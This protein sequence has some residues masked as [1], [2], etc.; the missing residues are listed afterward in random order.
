MRANARL[1][2]GMEYRGAVAPGR[3]EPGHDKAFSIFPSPPARR[4]V[5]W[6]APE[7]RLAVGVG[8]EGVDAWA[9]GGYS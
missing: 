1:P 8:Q 3:V 6:R 5:R 9:L 7:E 2:A 4:A